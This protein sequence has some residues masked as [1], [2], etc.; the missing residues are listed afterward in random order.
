MSRGGKNAI[1]LTGRRFGLLAITACAGRDASQR[2]LWSWRCDCG[3]TGQSKSWLLISGVTKSCGCYRRE[4]RVKHGHTR[5]N[6]STGT[7]NTWH[8][9]KHRCTER[10]GKRYKSHG[11]R[12]I[13]VCERWQTFEN[14]LA[15]MGERP[16]GTSID[17][18]N[19]DRDYEPGNCRWAD[20]VTQGRNRR[21]VF[22]TMELAERVRSARADGATLRQAGATVGITARYAGQICH[23]D[24]WK[25]AQ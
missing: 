1:D 14:F 13:R 17:R 5:K 2:L 19:N 12:G 4:F 8:N 18:I 6:D 7:Y 23:N 9:M 25:P 3:E 21:N 10:R 11:E 15:D 22:L 16:L 24:C 20:S